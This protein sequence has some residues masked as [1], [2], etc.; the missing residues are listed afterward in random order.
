MAT[1]KLSEGIRKFADDIVKLEALIERK[2]GEIQWYKKNNKINSLS[3]IL[4][5]RSSGIF[6]RFVHAFI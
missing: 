3:P 2:L 5:D 6:Y 4:A 1:D